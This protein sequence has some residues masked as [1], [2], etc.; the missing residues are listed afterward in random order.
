MRLESSG[1][2]VKGVLKDNGGPLQVD[3]ILIYQPNGDYQFSL[4]L[5]ARNP[6]DSQLRQAL[7]FLGTPNAAGKVSLSR[8]G[9]I[10]LASYL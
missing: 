4:S 7:R 2:V 8:R 3:G 6:G 1:D 5:S 9:H 10:D